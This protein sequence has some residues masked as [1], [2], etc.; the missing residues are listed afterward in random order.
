VL[1]P[2]SVNDPEPCLVIATFAVLPS[3]IIPANVVAVSVPE[4]NVLV[5]DPE[6]VLVM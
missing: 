5:P 6:A 3:W 1:L 4:V 2:E